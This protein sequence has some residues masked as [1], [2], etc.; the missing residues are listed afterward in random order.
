MGILNSLILNNCIPCKSNELAE[1]EINTEAI[2]KN[3][4]FRK[5]G[6][7]DSKASRTSKKSNERLEEV[8]CKI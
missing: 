6:S 3:S 7:L 1:I 5:F 2:F 4:R 8:L